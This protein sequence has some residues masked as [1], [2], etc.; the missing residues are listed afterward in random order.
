ME[1]YVKDVGKAARKKISCFRRP[2]STDRGGL[3]EC[4][5]R[6]PTTMFAGVVRHASCEQTT[7]NRVVTA[8]RGRRALLITYGTYGVIRRRFPPDNS[9]SHHISLCIGECCSRCAVTVRYVTCP[10]RHDSRVVQSGLTNSENN[11]HNGKYEV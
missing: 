10:E 7:K 9:D 4:R 1:T 8:L 2:K 6:P 11:F 3:P 5:I